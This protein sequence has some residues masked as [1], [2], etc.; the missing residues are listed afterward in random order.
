MYS[1]FTLFSSIYR[2]FS[3]IERVLGEKEVSV[4]ETFQVLSLY[5]HKQEGMATVTTAHYSPPIVDVQ[6]YPL[7]CVV[8]TVSS[9]VMME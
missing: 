6:K 5:G 9:R 8:W 1:M 7:V 2:T 4:M 3:K